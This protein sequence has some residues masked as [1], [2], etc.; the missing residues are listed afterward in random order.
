MRRTILIL[1]DSSDRIEGFKK[2]V[3]ALGPDY[4]LRLWQEAP[5]MIAECPK[6]FRETCLISLD[7]QLAR[8]PGF[9]GDPGNGLQVAEFLC[10]QD[11]LCPVI[12]H[13][14]AY[15]RRISMLNALSFAKWHAYIV[16][17]V[18]P[19]WI[20]ETWLGVVSKLLERR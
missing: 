16:S 4:T 5:T 2:A 8:R 7:Y 18:G 1:E 12:I 3:A 10:N 9:K 11:P 20:T 6:Y 15:D 14:S 17:P 13:T 19:S